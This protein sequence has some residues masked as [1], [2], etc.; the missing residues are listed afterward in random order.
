M[1][2]VGFEQ[3]VGGA[4]SFRAEQ[5]GTAETLPPDY[6]EATAEEIDRSVD[7]AARAY[8]E[9]R[10]IPAARRAELLER[11]AD[12]IEALGDPL[13]E[14]A[15]LETAL[16]KARLT[17]ERGRTTAQLR[18][19]AAM[20]RNGEAVD[21]RIDRAQP[22]RAPLPK[23]D[24]RQMQIGIGPVA[25]FGA[26]NFPLAFSVAGG[27]TASALA[28]GCP[29]IAKAHPHHP[30]TSEM[31]GR[32]LVACVRELGLPEGTFSMLHGKSHRVGTE[33]V[34]HPALAAVGFTGSLAGGRTLF[35]VATKR[36]HPIPV[37]AEMG[38]T[39]PV[40]LLPEALA[41]RADAIAEGLFQSV[42]L[43]AGQFCTNPGLVFALDDPATAAWLETVAA[44]F[45][46][47]EPAVTLHAG[48]AQAYRDRLSRAVGVPGVHC[49][50]ATATAADGAATPTLLVTD[51]S[52]FGAHPVLRE[53]I[54]GPCTVVVL[55]ANP[56]AME[57]LAR[58]LDGQLTATIHATEGDLRSHDNLARTLEFRAGRVV[59]N[60]FPTGVEV[61]SAMNHGGPYPATTD[62]RSTSVGSAAIRRFMRPICYQDAPPDRL[63][64][65]LTDDNPLAIPRWIDGR[66]TPPA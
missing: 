54:F 57:Q 7:L 14:R 19:F 21:A 50:H 46:A 13:L 48:I 38:S 43:G 23:P 47:A 45:G 6:A 41:T 18:M 22:N 56:G 29:V 2:L 61:C 10:V 36:P 58:D 63:P 9:L 65:E 31:I 35:D 4:A 8:T 17:G 39:N 16:P 52:T 27:D 60:G 30:G 25:V 53:E 5:A 64:P 44:K 51:G 62:V 59:F 40:F 12:A 37:Y 42:T 55:C 20:V 11:A 26:S 3:V 66:W 15:E 49:P 32:T 1:Q 33:L 34:Q 28:A 24:L